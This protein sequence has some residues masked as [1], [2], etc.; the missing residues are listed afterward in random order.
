MRFFL[1][2]APAAVEARAVVLAA[3]AAGLRG[4]AKKRPQPPPMAVLRAM[5]GVEAE[6][7]VLVAMR[8][9]K[10]VRGA[11]STTN[12]CTRAAQPATSK[13]TESFIIVR[14]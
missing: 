7:P 1:G 10:A 3:A 6:R 5:V 12:P 9:T 8:P 11:G 2:A 13:V 4:A 14:S